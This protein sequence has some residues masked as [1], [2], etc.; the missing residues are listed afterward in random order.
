M[1]N[2]KY[3]YIDCFG[4]LA[5]AGSAIITESTIII[6]PSDEAYAA[7]G[8]KRIVYGAV[9]RKKKGCEIEEYYE[10]DA[11]TIYVNYRCVNIETGKPDE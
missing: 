2:T 5:M 10:T 8:Y 6:N 7:H 3:G 9:P 4:N 1:K 11:A